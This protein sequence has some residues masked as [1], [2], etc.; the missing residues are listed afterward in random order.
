MS[1][2]GRLKRKGNAP[3]S[4]RHTLSWIRLAINVNDGET[5][6]EKHIDE[7]DYTTQQKSDVEFWVRMNKGREL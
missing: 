1:K 7:L 2:P 6:L 3:I 5:I 4:T